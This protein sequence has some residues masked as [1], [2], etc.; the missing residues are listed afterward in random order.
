MVDQPDTPSADAATMRRAW[1]ARAVT[2]P[3]YSI[4]AGRRSWDVGE[5]YARGRQLVEQIVDP[6]LTLLSVDPSGLR[7][8]EIGCGMGRLFE[9]LSHRFSEVWGTDISSEMIRRGQSVCPVAARW[10]LGDG[11]SLKE[12]E[13][14]SIDHAL[15]FEVFEH[16]PDS[17]IIG[18]YFAEMYRVLRAG[19]TFQAQLR[20]ASDT[21]KQALVRALPRPLRVVSAAVLKGVGILPV[22]GDIDTWLGC[23]VAPKDAMSMSDAIGFVRCEVLAN[24]FESSA[25]TT[26]HYWLLG[27][28]PDRG[29]RDFKNQ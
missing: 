28:K 18:G 4:D 19:G 11:L 16:I 29:G 21:P 24:D 5:F 12:V 13:D 6:A 9:G 26:S 15:S 2:N 20:R 22:R 14:G 8:L 17:A 7:V 10:M 3:L 25:E 1:D 23:V 27:R